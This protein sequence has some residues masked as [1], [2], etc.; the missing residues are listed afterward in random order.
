M[1]SALRSLDIVVHAST[2]PEPFGMTIIEAMA[3]GRVV[4]IPLAGGAVE[5]VHEGVDAVGYAPADPA[6]LA[7]VLGDLMTDPARRASLAAEARRWTTAAFD[8]RRLGSELRQV[9]DSV[10]C[11]N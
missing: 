10:L 6:S 9:Y 11:G 1:P 4:V 8:A 5:I 3:C 2:R 7:A